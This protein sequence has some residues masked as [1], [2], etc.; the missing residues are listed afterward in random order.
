MSTAPL[1]ADK[2][3]QAPKDAR[4]VVNAEP[5]GAGIGSLVIVG[6]G[7]IPDPIRLRFLD[8]A[9]GKKARLVVIPT[10][11]ELG[12][13]TGTFRSFAYWKA[14]P[15][16][17]VTL[18]HTLDR[19]KANDPTFVKPLTEATGVWLSGGDQARLTAAYRGTAAP[20][21]GRRR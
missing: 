9:G 19:E 17:S 13:R 2:P 21:R 20:R 6:G 14:Q 1:K 12:H 10:A 8:L 3:P 4:P 16:A 15:A 18:L 5:Q 7:F 11:S